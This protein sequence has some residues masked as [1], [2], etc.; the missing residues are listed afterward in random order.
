MSWQDKAI[1][2]TNGSHFGAVLACALGREIPAP[3]FN[4]KASVTSDGFVMC[5]F[6]GSD[7]RDHMGAFVGSLSDLERNSVGLA[8]HLELSAVERAEFADALLKWIGNDYSR[9]AVKCA[10]QRLRDGVGK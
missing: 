5:S 4:G 7:G 3:H 10:A 6:T 1:A 8:K 2:A 9:G